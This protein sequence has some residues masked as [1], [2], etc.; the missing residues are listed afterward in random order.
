MLTQFLLKDMK[1]GVVEGQYVL[2][3][4][5]AGTP[6]TLVIIVII[7]LTIIVTITLTI[8]LTFTLTIILTIAY[9]QP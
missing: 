8:I 2:S 4:A 1:L 9:H 6:I 5:S 3:P 7:T